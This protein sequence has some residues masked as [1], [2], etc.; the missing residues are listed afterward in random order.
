MEKITV[1]E[2]LD[3]LS[4]RP[5]L[6]VVTAESPLKDVVRAMVKG[7]RRRI[8]YVVDRSATLLGAISLD[9]L[10]DVIFYHYITDRVS[11][12]LVVSEHMAKLFASEKAEDVMATELIVCHEDENLHAVVSRMIENNI[13]DLPVLD[14]EGRVIADLDILDLLELWLQKGPRAFS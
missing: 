14:R 3:S 6:P 10:K 11:D 7:H 9:V 8:V 12:A 4:H 13:K 2:F 5:E 1:R